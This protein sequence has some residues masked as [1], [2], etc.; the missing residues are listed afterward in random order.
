MAFHAIRSGEGDVFV[1]AR[2]ETVS[3]FPQGKSD[4]MPDTHNAYY[5]EAEARTAAR[6]AEGST[7]TDPRTQGG[8]PDAY[9]AMAQTAEDVAQLYG[10]TLEEQD[11]FGVRS[12]NLAE[13]AAAGGFWELDIT[14]VTAP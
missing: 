14:P 7:W 8:V 5:A 10:V 2:V 3:R 6:S 9:I 13:K 4:G 1:S 12:Q 11:R